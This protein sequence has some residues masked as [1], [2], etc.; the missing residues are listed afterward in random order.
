[1]CFGWTRETR[2]VRGAQQCELRDVII[3]FAAHSRR[4]HTIEIKITFSAKCWICIYFSRS[5]RQDVMLNIFSTIVIENCHLSPNEF[6]FY[7]ENSIP[8]SNAVSIASIQ[9]KFHK[10]FELV[11]TNEINTIKRKSKFKKKKK[12]RQ[13]Y[14]TLAAPPHLA[15]RIIIICHHNKMECVDTSEAGEWEEFKLS[16]VR[17]WS[18]IFICNCFQEYYDVEKRWQ[19]KGIKSNDELNRCGA[20]R[21]LHYTLFIFVCIPFELCLSF[22]LFVFSLLF[23]KRQMFKM[24]F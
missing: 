15:H 14:A 21:L 22:V 19:A 23:R 11:S 1:M 6:A 20:I 13:A 7:P 24:S 17:T 8:E 2:E 12:M 4:S 5:R 16:S 10:Y 3:G 9:Q 18:H